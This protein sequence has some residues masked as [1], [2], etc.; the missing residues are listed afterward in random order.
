MEGKSILMRVHEFR[1]AKD[2]ERSDLTGISA[3]SSHFISDIT[4]DFHYDDMHH[5][6][7]VKSVIG[8][9]LIPIKAG[10]TLR[11]LTRGK[12]EEE[13][14]HFMFDLFQMFM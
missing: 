14:M 10:T 8:M 6:V 9:L 7:D 12:D 3:K 5:K 4:L 11:L 1:I 2:L 13:A